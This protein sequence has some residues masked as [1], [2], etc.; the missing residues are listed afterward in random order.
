M[1]K[2]KNNID[3]Q[4]EKDSGGAINAQV[5]FTLTGDDALALNS[6]LY[7]KKQK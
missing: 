4:T 7:K 5:N 2:N 1:E 3:E 6:D